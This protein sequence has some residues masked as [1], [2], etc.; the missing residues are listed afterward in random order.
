[1]PAILQGHDVLATSATGSGKTAAY[2]L[3]LL[4][5]LAQAQAPLRQRPVRCLVL[6]PTR[7][8]ASQVSDLW[9]DLA[10]DMPAPR[11]WSRCSAACP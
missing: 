7:E 6:V 2:A 4:Q 1:V 10:R 8:L 3:P 11:K 5:R 9:H